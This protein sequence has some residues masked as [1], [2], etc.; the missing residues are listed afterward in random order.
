M[1]S[2]LNQTSGLPPQAA[3]FAS[4]LQQI[5]EAGDI[6]YSKYKGLLEMQRIPSKETREAGCKGL[7]R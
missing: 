5:Q 4:H 7:E 3:D 1:I 2:V 6:P